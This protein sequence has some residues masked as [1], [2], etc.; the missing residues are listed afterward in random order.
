[1][2]T[3]HFFSALSLVAFLALGLFLSPAKNQ[4]RGEPKITGTIL[5]VDGTAVAGAT[6]E[7]AQDCDHGGD[8]IETRK[9]VSA[10]DGTFSLPAY[11]PRCS[12][13]RL[14]ASKETDFWLPSED[15]L[16]SEFGPWTNERIVVD[17]ASVPP[18]RPVRIVL[19]S[20]G[21]KVAI[22]VRDLATGR[23][24]FADLWYEKPDQSNLVGADVPT[25]LDGSATVYLLT[26]GKYTVRVASFTCGNSHDESHITADGPTISVLVRPAIESNEVIEIDSRKIKALKNDHGKF[27]P[28][29]AS[30]NCSRRNSGRSTSGATRPNSPR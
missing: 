17:V 24:V 3:P 12:R 11:D 28:D 5:L 23:F 30:P 29:P 18:P 9:S 22:R 6:V 19:N 21:G 13:Y 14:I 27:T 10:A 2:K 4:A 25:G 26:P 7:T 20:R 8:A 1:M 16:N 15:L